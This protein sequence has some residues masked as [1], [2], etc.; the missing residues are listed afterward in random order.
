MVGRV[1]RLGWFGIPIG[2]LVGAV[3]FL[4]FFL[5]DAAFLAGL[6]VAGVGGAI[7]PRRDRWVA[8]VV[9]IAVGYLFWAV[10]PQRGAD[11]PTNLG[12]V[13]CAVGFALG[14]LL[15]TLIALVRRYIGSVAADQSV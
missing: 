12:V 4:F 15:G 1:R 11:N 3:L 8:I 5:Y 6:A 10:I 14:A 7:L 9:G 13:F 2:F